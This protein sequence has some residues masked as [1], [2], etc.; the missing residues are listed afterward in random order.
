MLMPLKEV[1]A[2]LENTKKVLENKDMSREE[3]LAELDHILNSVKNKIIDKIRESNSA[4]PKTTACKRCNEIGLM[5][6]RN[7]HRETGKWRMIYEDG[8][9]HKCGEKRIVRL[10]EVVEVTD[11]DNFLDALKKISE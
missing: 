11:Q 3:L 10:E 5:W 8:V 6:D 7:F 1:I 9:I 4:G 2:I